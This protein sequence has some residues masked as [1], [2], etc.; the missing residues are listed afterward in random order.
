VTFSR[1]PGFEIGPATRL[2]DFAKECKEKKLKSF[3]SYKTKADLE[4]ILGKYKVGGNDITCIP[5]FTPETKKIDV[6][7][8]KMRNLGP[9]TGKNEV[10]RCSYIEGILH[11]TKRLTKKRNTL[12]LNLRLK[13]VKQQVM[14]ILLS[15]N[16]RYRE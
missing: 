1:W 10:V 14:L 8:G 6:N 13:T 12:N 3:V 9:T 4:K 7:D 11:I 2:A 16:H 5:P 15:K